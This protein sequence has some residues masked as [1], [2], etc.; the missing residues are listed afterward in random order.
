MIYLMHTKTQYQ[1]LL[2]WQWCLYSL[3]WPEKYIIFM[4]ILDLSVDLNLIFTN[5]LNPEW[6]VLWNFSREDR[7]HFNSRWASILPG[8]MRS[9]ISRKV[10]Q[11]FF[12]QEKKHYMDCQMEDSTACNTG[13]M[14][15]Q[16]PLCRP[17]LTPVFDLE[18]SKV[19]HAI[20][21]P[22]LIKTTPGATLLSTSWNIFLSMRIS[23]F[24]NLQPCSHSRCPY[25]SLFFFL[26]VYFPAGQ[27]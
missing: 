25:P 19:W 22:C 2:C 18:I 12:S 13:I 27:R 3:W 20:R 21:R 1:L 5:I 6:S 16:P 7:I 10:L 26:I 4:C 15:S 14:A 8:T 17:C 11:P 24:S 23:F 9:V